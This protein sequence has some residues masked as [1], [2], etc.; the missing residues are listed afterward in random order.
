MHT[1]YSTHMYTA[2][3]DIKISANVFSIDITH[4][5]VMSACNNIIIKTRD[6]YK[7]RVHTYLQ[8][9]LIKL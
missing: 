3:T 1:R 2:H 8:S 5:S 9:V 4:T 6:Q 7:V